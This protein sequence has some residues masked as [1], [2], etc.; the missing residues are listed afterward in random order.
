MRHITTYIVV[1]FMLCSCNK[2]KTEQNNTKIGSDVITVGIETRAGLPSSNYGIYAAPYNN[3][4]MFSW[5]NPASF[6]TTLLF[7]NLSVKVTNDEL[8]F[9]AVVYRYPI[10]D[11]LSLFLYHPYNTSAEPTSIPIARKEIYDTSFPPELI[12]DKYPDYLGGDVDI[13]VVGGSPEGSPNIELSHLTSRIRFRIINPASDAFTIDN[14]TL[15]GIKW[16]GALNAHAT[17]AFND[18]VYTSATAAEDL[19]LFENFVVPGSQTSPKN[20]NIKD[21]YIYNE[22][23]AGVAYDDDYLYH[24]LVPPLNEDQL[25]SVALKI[26]YTR[27]G[28]SYTDVPPIPLRRLLIERWDPG[29]S[30]CYTIQIE[31][32]KIEFIEA[33]IEEWKEETYV[34]SITIE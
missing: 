8:D 33:M 21:L 26:E 20:I 13:S 4:N 2:E 7:D 19:A 15:V 12:S 16:D 18:P 10:T 28:H 25:N 14:A 23:E 22:D 27:Y 31:S 32:F 30:Y 5:R 9:D 1:I 24:I 3:G 17:N 11:S 34:G 6:P 29:K